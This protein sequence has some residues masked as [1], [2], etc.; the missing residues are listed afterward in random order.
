[1]TQGTVLNRYHS[2]RNLINLH[3]YGH[4][5]VT[6][7]IQFGLGLA[8]GGLNHQSSRNWETHRR[9]ME[10]VVHQALG[11]VIHRDTE[12]L[13]NAPHINDAF[14]GDKAMSSGVQNWEVCIKATRNIVRVHDGHFGS[15][16]NSSCTHESDVGPRDRQNAR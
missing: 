15:Q 1:M 12:I 8:L 4:H 7:S 3:S 9:R 14:M 10:S 5:R 2:R 6:E 16:T 11:D 13:G